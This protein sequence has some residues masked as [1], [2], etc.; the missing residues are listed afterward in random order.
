MIALAEGPACIGA[1]DLECAVA[2]QETAIEYRHAR[3][4]GSR[5]HAV[6]RD[7]TIGSDCHAGILT[8]QSVPSS[9][10]ALACWPPSEIARSSMAFALDLSPCFTEISPRW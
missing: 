2:V 5:E 1:H 4:A 6:D 9:A 3:F 7:P 10:L 8:D